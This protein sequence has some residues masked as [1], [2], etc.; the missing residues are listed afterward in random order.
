MRATHWEFTMHHF[1]ALTSAFQVV[2]VF[3]ASTRVSLSLAQAYL[4]RKITIISC[5]PRY[6]LS[7]L[8]TLLLIHRT[9]MRSRK[10]HDIDFTEE[11]T[12]TLTTKGLPRM[13]EPVIC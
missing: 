4:H 9:I 2:E 13:P 11:E 8:N 5:T 3:L 7:V 12:Q 10:C 6:L 1:V